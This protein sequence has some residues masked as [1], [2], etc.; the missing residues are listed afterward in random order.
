MIVF[1]F[2]SYVSWYC[3]SNYFLLGYFVMEDGRV[4]IVEC[5][6]NII[7]GQLVVEKLKVVDDVLIVDDLGVDFLEMV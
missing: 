7:I 5:V 4:D 6:K 3:F 1:I 2:F